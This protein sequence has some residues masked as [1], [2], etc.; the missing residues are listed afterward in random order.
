MMSQDEWVK[1]AL[2]ACVEQGFTVELEDPAT[3][4][5]FA[6]MLGSVNRAAAG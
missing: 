6:E 4:A 2:D 5:F 3:I 1:D